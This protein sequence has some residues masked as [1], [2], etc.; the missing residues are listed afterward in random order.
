M[1][2]EWGLDKDF[3]IVESRNKEIGIVINELEEVFFRTSG[4]F[5]DKDLEKIKKMFSIKRN[6]D[7]FDK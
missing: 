6:K 1:S 7:T 4:M 3:K 5:D 2:N